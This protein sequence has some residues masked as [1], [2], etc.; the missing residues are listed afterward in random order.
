[1][2]FGFLVH[3]F[4][5]KIFQK[6]KQRIFVKFALLWLLMIIKCVAIVLKSASHAIAVYFMSLA[7]FGQFTE[8]DN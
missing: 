1:M 3:V 8:K 6:E 4:A 7:Y 5:K 2:C